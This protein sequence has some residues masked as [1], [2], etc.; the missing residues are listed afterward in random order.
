MMRLISIFPMAQMA[1]RMARTTYYWA[2]LGLGTLV[3]SVAP[4]GIPSAQAQG[5]QGLPVVSDVRIGLHED[6]TRVVLDLSHKVKFSVFTLP[7]PY[8]V[9]INLPEVKWALPAHGLPENKGLMARFRFGLFTPGTSRMVIDA[10]GPLTV[11]K[12]FLLD[13]IDGKSHRLVL[14]L[15]KASETAFLED[16]ARQKANRPKATTSSAPTEASIPVPMRKPSPSGKRVIAIDPGH[17]GVD[18]GTVSRSGTY[19]KHITLAIARDIKKELEATGKFKVVLTRERDIF[20]RLRGRV[21]RAR[22]AGAELFIS[23][24]ADSIKNPK[25]RGLSVYTLSEKASDKEAAALAEKENKAD[26]IAGL[27]LSTENTE[28]SNILI[29]LAQRESMNRSAKFAQGLVSELKREV[30]LLRNTHRF[31]GFAVLKAPDMPS[32]LIETGFLSNKQDERNLLSRKYR[33]KLAR[34][35]ARGVGRY[36]ETAQEAQIH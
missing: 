30:K 34:A 26:L 35:I 18:P 25:T 24:H 31:A 19:E 5:T 7:A 21:Q 11:A 17:G 10:R 32:V 6:R 1:S 14:D 23:M 33:S 20:L 29:D 8:R 27:D 9:V 4:A 13:P 22:A 16:M 3:A 36:F 15:V 2:V 28:V 12:A